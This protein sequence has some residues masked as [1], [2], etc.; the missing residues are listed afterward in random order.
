L[1]TWDISIEIDSVD[2]PALTAQWLTMTIT[3]P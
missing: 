1:L 3:N 2:T